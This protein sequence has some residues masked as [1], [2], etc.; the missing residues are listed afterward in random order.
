MSWSSL[1][2]LIPVW[3]LNLWFLLEFIENMCYNRNWIV[4]KS[5]IWLMFNVW[6]QLKRLQDE[7]ELSENR[8]KMETLE[9]KLSIAKE[10]NESLEKRVQELDLRTK[11][12]AYELK[13][14][15][16]KPSL[17]NIP[18]PPPPP[19]LPVLPKNP[20]EWVYCPLCP[21]IK[22][23]LVI[24]Q[25]IAKLQSCICYVTFDINLIFSWDG[26]WLF[27]KKILPQQNIFKEF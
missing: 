17:P 3:I 13:E 16:S 25:L 6:W 1:I 20:L 9:N 10:E 21:E 26:F 27:K 7:L 15:L 23:F 2:Q 5:L 22:E 14:A 18:P 11:E 8:E 19:P 24:H 4:S 12:L